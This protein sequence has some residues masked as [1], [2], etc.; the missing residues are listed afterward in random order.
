MFA[1]GTD[2]TYTALEW[3]LTELIKHSKTMKKVQE[4]V[5]RIAGSK[6]YINEDHIEKMFYL[7]A[8]IKETLRLHPPVPLLLPRQATK[9]VQVGGYNIPAKSRVIINAWAIG[10]DPAS[11]EEPEKF[12]PERFLDNCSSF[13]GNDFHF[14]PFGAGRRGCPGAT[15][16]IA[17]VEL[18]LS[19]LLY[20]FD[21]A[22]PDEQ[23]EED[24]DVDES[25]GITIHR[26]FPLVVVATPHRF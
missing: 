12:K 20:K 5:R 7:K 15:F 19:N 24:L 10:R 25:N 23:R 9:D 26:K 2:T 14:I 13:K 21:W 16:A 3:A 1:G 22:L 18:V 11:W 4:E 17:I 6:S 8:V